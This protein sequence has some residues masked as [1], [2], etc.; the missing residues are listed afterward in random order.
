MKH[1]SLFKKLLRPG[2]K[3]RKKGLL[4]SSRNLQSDVQAT[5]VD[6]AVQTN[7]E[8]KVNEEVDE[9]SVH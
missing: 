1:R 8:V 9:A 4:V 6:S 5:L 2:A 7:I 3:Q